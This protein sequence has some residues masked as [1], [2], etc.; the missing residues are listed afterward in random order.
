[1]PL[2][3]EENVVASFAPTV[4]DVNAPTAAEVGAG[5]D[6]SSYI[7]KN[8]ITF[9]STRNMVDTG[10]IDNR[11]NSEYPGSS[12]GTL[13]ITF[14]VSNRDDAT[15]AE[16][17]FATAETAGFWI[18]GFQGSNDTA[19]D[20]VDVYQVVSH[21]YVRNNPGADT[22]QRLVVSFGLQDQALGVAVVA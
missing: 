22:E 7:P 21:Q 14:K 4:A 9:P 13:Q 8:G 15:A 5:V 3:Y 19:A 12:G 6:Y 11:F 2:V 16:T 10:T 1:M 17:A 18:F 20:V